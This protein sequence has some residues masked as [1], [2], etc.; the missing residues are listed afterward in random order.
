MP[1]PITPITIPAVPAQTFDQLWIYNL[2]AHSPAVGAG[3]LRLEGLPFD[4]LSLG[5]DSQKQVF[6][7]DKLFE[8][9]DPE[10]GCPEAITAF[11]YI[12]AAI[13]A[14]MAWQE[15]RKNQV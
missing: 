11:G 6:Q 14:L 5:P 1:I 8:L 4:G 2:N 13:P 15:A 9:L 7:T 3:S 12:Q 10:I